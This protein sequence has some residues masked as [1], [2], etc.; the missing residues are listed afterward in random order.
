MALYT[1]NGPNT[2]E[3]KKWLSLISDLAP[4]IQPDVRTK[5]PLVHMRDTTA[6]IPASVFGG[7]QTVSL[8]R[9]SPEAI[10]IM[11]KHVPV[12]PRDP[13]TALQIHS[14]RGP[15]CQPPFSDSVW[16]CREPHFMLEILGMASSK[17]AYE[18]PR[19]WAV[20][21]RKDLEEVEG[22]LEGTYISLTDE[23]NISLERIYGMHLKELKKLKETYDPN[24]VFKHTVPQL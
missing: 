5:S 17:K 2:D 7:A 1:W 18:I 11:A 13:C 21:F 10:S 4:V 20:N 6:M 23:K 15:S 22:A 24:R 3:A 16:R 14:L 19:A 12:M 8:A 9:C